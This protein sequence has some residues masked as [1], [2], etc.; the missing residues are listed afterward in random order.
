[1]LRIAA[2]VMVGIVL[3]GALA[4]GLDFCLRTGWPDY[5]AVEKAMAFTVPMMLARL[6]EST[7]ALLVASW[8]MTRIAPGSR[9]APWI[10]GIV[11]LAFFVPVH[12]GLWTKFPIWYHAYF[13][14][15]LLAL[16]LIV[17]TAS[18]TKREAAAA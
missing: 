12:Y 9:V 2:G 1:M 7:L 17:A 13:L 14:S 15:S 5:A 11:L 3:W 16:P 6:A 8:A 4:V 18:G 10:V